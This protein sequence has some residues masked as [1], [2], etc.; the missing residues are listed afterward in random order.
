MKLEPLSIAL[1]LSR[2]NSPRVRRN[3]CTALGEIGGE[4]AVLGLAERA[5]SHAEADPEVRKTAVEALDALSAGLPRALQAL[6][7]MLREGEPDEDVRR[8]AVAAL[9]KRAAEP[10]ARQALVELLGAHDEIPRIRRQITEALAPAAGDDPIVMTALITE[11]ISSN[12]KEI[13]RLA[14]KALGPFLAS[15]PEALTAVIG[16]ASS[17]SDGEVRRLAL[18]ALSDVATAA[19]NQT[20]D[21]DL[22][23][24]RLS[25]PLALL[26]RSNIL[27]PIPKG[28][29]RRRLQEAKTAQAEIDQYLPRSAGSAVQMRLPGLAAALVLPVALWLGLIGYMGGLPLLGSGLKAYLIQ[30]TVLALASTLLLPLFA[31]PAAAAADRWAGG[32]REE[33]RVLTWAAALG[34]CGVLAALLMSLNEVA[35]VA[36]LIFAGTVITLSAIRFASLVS[37]RLVSWRRLGAWIQTAVGASAGLLSLFL[38]GELVNHYRPVASAYTLF[39]VLPALVAAAATFAQVDNRLEDLSTSKWR[40]LRAAMTVLLGLPAIFALGVVG[41]AFLRA[42][43]P[44]NPLTTASQFGKTKPVHFK[45]R[46][47]DELPF[48]L[49]FPQTI[50]VELASTENSVVLVLSDATR[51]IGRL[52]ES[53]AKDRELQDFLDRSPAAERFQEHLGSGDY[54]LRFQPLSDVSLSVNDAIAHWGA[55]YLPSRWQSIS[56]PVQDKAGAKAPNLRD[57]DRDKETRSALLA[58]VPVTFRYNLREVSEKAVQAALELQGSAGPRESDLYAI[59]RTDSPEFG[60]GSI[61]YS[62]KLPTANKRVQQGWRLL[63]GWPLAEEKPTSPPQQLISLGPQPNFVD[64]WERA[65]SYHAVFTK[66]AADAEENKTALALL[67]QCGATDVAE[68]I[69]DSDSRHVEERELQGR[70]F[71]YDSLDSSDWISPGTLLRG[72]RWMGP[73]KGQAGFEVLSGWVRKELPSL[74]RL[75]EHNVIPLRSFETWSKVAPCL[76]RDGTRAGDDAWKQIPLVGDA[77]PAM[78]SVIPPLSAFHDLPSFSLQS[79]EAGAGKWLDADLTHEPDEFNGFL[80]I[81]RPEFPHEGFAGVGSIVR[82]SNWDTDGAPEFEIV[83]GWAAEAGRES[84]YMH[85]AEITYLGKTFDPGWLHLARMLRARAPKREAGFTL[86]DRLGGAG[87]I[88]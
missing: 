42:A 58:N 40:G 72:L 47:G 82:G 50:S 69:K 18:D 80:I 34:F 15:H 16:V 19:G 60:A 53:S 3:A 44:D 14:V 6:A 52:G 24:L 35:L 84:Y 8:R 25:S 12:D 23:R 20:L 43:A 85:A 4:G 59:V 17:E 55:L 81:V 86:L 33:A 9:G 68:M 49:E 67:L 66:N 11:G 30:S 36:V 31:T 88:R 73:G 38:L 13:R 2:E 62:R 29:L 46:I 22:D 28:S 64:L 63:L 83:Y 21:F 77:P 57:G 54:F 7:G 78:S 56:G 32:L 45:A 87:A 48:S 70:L 41:H 5:R 79:L 10:A 39:L 1:S 76:S 26:R 61:L 27:I 75:S 37:Y 71:L 51:E 65:R 74:V